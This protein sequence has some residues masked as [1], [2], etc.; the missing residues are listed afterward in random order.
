M[1]A[2]K[3]KCRKNYSGDPFSK[4]EQNLSLPHVYNLMME[5]QGFCFARLSSSV[6]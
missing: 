2:L 6:K 1:E 5:K 3:G 4:Y